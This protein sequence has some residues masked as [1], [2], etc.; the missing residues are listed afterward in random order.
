MLAFHNRF[1]YHNSNLQ[2]LGLKGTIFVT[3][4]AISVMISPPTQTTQGVFVSLGKRRQKSTNHT[5]YVNKY[6][7]ELHQLFSVGRL[8]YANYKLKTKIFLR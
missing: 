2:V 5:K 3:L 1:E 7:T 6:W 8:M 4:C